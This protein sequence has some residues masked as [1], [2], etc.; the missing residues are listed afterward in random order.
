MRTFSKL[1]LVALVMSLT[2]TLHAQDE[3]KDDVKLSDDQVAAIKKWGDPG[4]LED[5]EFKQ[6]KVGQNK[7]VVSMLIAAKDTKCGS[8]VHM[9]AKSGFLGSKDGV[10]FVAVREGG[11]GLALI[12]QRKVLWVAYD[13]TEGFQAPVVVTPIRKTDP[14]TRVLTGWGYVPPSAHT[15][16]LVILPKGK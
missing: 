2:S 6:T 3:K 12:Q 14:K 10:D 4:K 13:D 1:A 15:G 16:F 11:S 8:D 7:T 9:G 5:K